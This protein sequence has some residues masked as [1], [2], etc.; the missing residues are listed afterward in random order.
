MSAAGV[1]LCALALAL[2]WASLHHGGD[3][4]MSWERGTLDGAQQDQRPRSR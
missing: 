2:W 4:G 1:A 3:I